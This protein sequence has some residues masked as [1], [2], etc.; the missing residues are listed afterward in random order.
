MLLGNVNHSLENLRKE[1]LRLILGRDLRHLCA[2]SYSV[3]SYL[4]GDDLPRR[5]KEAKE[6][7]RIR[8]SQKP[9][10]HTI[11]VVTTIN[12]Y[13]LLTNQN[14]LVSSKQ[15]LI[16]LQQRAFFRCSPEAQKSKPAATT[17]GLPKLHLTMVSN[18]PK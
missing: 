6:T 10:D 12:M 8:L 11:I 4:L 14:N 17:L 18:T 1:K 16:I 5:I 15:L 2:S 13:I 7:V 9:Q 3:T